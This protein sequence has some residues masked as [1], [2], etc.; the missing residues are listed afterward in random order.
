MLASPFCELDVSRVARA[1]LGVT[2]SFRRVSF[3]AFLSF[4]PA[5]P[6]DRLTR[7]GALLWKRVLVLLVMAMLRGRRRF[8]AAFFPLFSGSPLRA[9]RPM[10][11]WG[12]N[13]ET[14]GWALV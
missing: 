10:I 8:F 5:A 2:S 11:C 13:V 7:L 3:F 12:R 1:L 14:R 6:G 9:K 4:P